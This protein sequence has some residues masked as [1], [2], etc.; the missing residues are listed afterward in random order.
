MV[1]LVVVI[2]VLG[3]APHLLLSLSHTA[4]SGLLTGAGVAP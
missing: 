1:A 3:V 2:V 4:A